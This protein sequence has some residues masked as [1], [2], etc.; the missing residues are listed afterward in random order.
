MS[1]IVVDKLA[2][3]YDFDEV[4]VTALAGVTLKIEAGEFVAI[5]GP[6]GSGKSTL[7]HILGLLDTPTSGKYLLQGEDVSGLSED[8]RAALR[9][10]SVGFIFQQ[11]NLL[12][13]TTALENVSLPILYH[14]NKKDATARATKLLQRVG[15][16]DRLGHMPN[17]LSGGQQQRVA[18]ARA[19]VNDPSLIFA[20][21][22]TGN[23]DTKS[24]HEIMSL[25]DDL[26]A[27]GKT[28]I[29]VTHELEVAR[30][31]RRIITLRDGKVVSDEVGAARS[32][33]LKKKE[34]VV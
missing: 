7:M 1:F 12:A 11:F 8:E 13:R 21:E 31:A 9:A 33:L 4:R 2:K 20:D 26:A 25:L 24:G 10:K 5:I 14:P 30:H 23:L 3:H 28:V 15:L 22:P 18:I 19:L 6:S 34:A 32:D 16:G 29:M 27:E 17:Q